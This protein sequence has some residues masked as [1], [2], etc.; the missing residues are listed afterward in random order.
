MSH[1]ELNQSSQILL[2]DSDSDSDNSSDSMEVS[3]ELFSDSSDDVLVQS[4]PKRRKRKD[5]GSDGTPVHLPA[6][7]KGNGPG[8]QVI[9]S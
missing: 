5:E 8:R 6:A 9:N 7:R 4:H 2:S 1:D 3:Y